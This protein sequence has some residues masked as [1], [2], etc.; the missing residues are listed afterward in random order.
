LNFIASVSGIYESV[1]AIE[2]KFSFTNNEKKVVAKG[3][4]QIGL[5]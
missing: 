5:L 1:Q 2:F 3:H 4:V